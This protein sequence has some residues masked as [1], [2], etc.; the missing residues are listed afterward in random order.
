MDA[1]LA[2]SCAAFTYGAVKIVGKYWNIDS[3]WSFVFESRCS[4]LLSRLQDLNCAIQM[5]QVPPKANAAIGPA[6]ASLASTVKSAAAALNLE[7]SKVVPPP[8]SREEDKRKWD[9]FVA[10]LSKSWDTAAERKKNEKPEPP[11]ERMKELMIAVHEKV[12]GV[13]RA[14]GLKKT[15]PTTPPSSST[16]APPSPIRA[17]SVSTPSASASHASPPPTLPSQK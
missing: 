10:A 2:D 15:P 17:A 8:V 9:E 5:H 3:V 1:A 13:M 7:T 14:V 16:T 12:A 6:S 4:G 11:R